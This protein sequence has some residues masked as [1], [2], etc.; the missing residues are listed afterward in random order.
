MAS[1]SSAPGNSPIAA[2]MRPSQQAQRQPLG[3]PAGSVRAILT[4]IILAL[5]WTL[6][7]LPK[8]KVKDIP[9]YLFYLMFLSLGSFFAAHGRSI[10]GPL[11]G[12]RSP[13]YLPR[14]SLR[15]L[16]ILGF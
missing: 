3:L 4:F 7:L 12:T 5:I 14:G 6:M 16:I 11:T 13:L 1:S 15:F 10:A 9:L 2:G 8:D